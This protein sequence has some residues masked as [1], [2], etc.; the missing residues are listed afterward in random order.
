MNTDLFYE[1]S[2][3]I[4]GD[5]SGEFFEESSRKGGGEVEMNRLVETLLEV[6]VNEEPEQDLGQLQEDVWW[7]V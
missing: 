4:F 5:E 3:S 7:N 1:L 2:G 6:L